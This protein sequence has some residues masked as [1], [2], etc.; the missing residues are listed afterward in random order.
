MSTQIARFRLVPIYLTLCMAGSFTSPAFTESLELE[1]ITVTARKTEVALQDAAIAVSVTSG[2][3]FD[4]S[5]ILKLDNFNGY[6]PG[7]VVAK[8]DGAGR[9]VS[10][11][12]IGW[13]TDYSYREKPVMCTM[14]F[15]KE[16]PD[17]GS[18]TIIADCCAAYQALD[19]TAQLKLDPLI[20]HHSFKHFMETREYNQTK[21]SAKMQ[22]ENP[23]VFH[24]LI[25]THPTNKRKA[26]W[27]STGTV[28]QVVGMPVDEGITLIDQ[29]VEYV[30]QE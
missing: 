14:L 10:I 11:R 16:V 28:K 22:K 26:L 4:R 25:R 24:P 3:D 5:N 9:V 21:L 18:D 23:D 29:L 27:V 13:H 1:E 12:G 20:L 30:T 7:L 8:N 15:A 2:E 19:P 17:E 6:T